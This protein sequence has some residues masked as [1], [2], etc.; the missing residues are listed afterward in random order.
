MEK[1]FKGFKL[2]NGTVDGFNET[3]LENDIIHF[4]RTSETK[5]NGYLHF[6]WK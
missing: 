5:Y 3:N 6:N 1:I 2:I 4:I